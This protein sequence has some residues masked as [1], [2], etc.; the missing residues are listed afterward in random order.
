M[1]ATI[2]K[3]SPLKYQKYK[4]ERDAERQ[5]VL[6]VKLQSGDEKIK[7]CSCGRLFQF[8]VYTNKPLSDKVIR[9]E[10]SKCLMCPKRETFTV[11]RTFGNTTRTYTYSV[12]K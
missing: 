7:R 5:T 8:I 9:K 10:L 1:T 11:K 4:A 3:Y 12:Y 2:D 6:L